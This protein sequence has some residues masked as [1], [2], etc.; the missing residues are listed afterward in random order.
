[1]LDELPWLTEQSLA[2]ELREGARQV[3]GFAPATTGLLAVT[4]SGA[5]LPAG[6][7]DVVWGPDELV[8]AWRP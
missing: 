7:V 2:S 4:R 3:P 8:A 5:D 1:M 6:A